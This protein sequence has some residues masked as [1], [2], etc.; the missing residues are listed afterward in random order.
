MATKLPQ[1]VVEC[2]MCPFGAAKRLLSD[3]AYLLQ[4]QGI[5]ARMATYNQPKLRKTLPF[6]DKEFP[7]D[8]I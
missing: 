6:W 2:C 7:Q 4:Q 1:G 8:K 5:L 3:L